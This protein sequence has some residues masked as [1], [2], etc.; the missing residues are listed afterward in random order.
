MRFF[1]LR[2]TLRPLEQLLIL[3]RA[4]SDVKIKVITQVKHERER[5]ALYVLNNPVEMGVHEKAVYLLLN[6]LGN[7]FSQSSR[8]QHATLSSS[9]IRYALDACE[10]WIDHHWQLRKEKRYKHVLGDRG[11]VGMAEW[12]EYMDC[13]HGV[14]HVMWRLELGSQHI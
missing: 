13:Q 9:R 6:S 5:L 4:K 2:K 3:V 12:S 11:G 8:K 7:R 10:E 1:F 14:A